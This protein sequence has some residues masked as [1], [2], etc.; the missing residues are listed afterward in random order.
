MEHQQDRN[1]WNLVG[2]TGVYIQVDL[3]CLKLNT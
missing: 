1:K 2:H 3:K